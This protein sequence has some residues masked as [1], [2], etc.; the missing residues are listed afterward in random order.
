MLKIKSPDLKALEKTFSTAGKWHKVFV[1]KNMLTLGERIVF[2]MRQATSKHRYTGK[3]EESVKSTYKARVMRLEIGPRAKR[4]KWDA[5]LLLERGTGPIPNLPFGPIQRWAEFRG[6]PAG[7]VWMSIKRKGVKAHPYLDRTLARGD[8]QVAIKNTAFRIGQ[9]L[10]AFS[11]QSLKS[12]AIKS[13]VQVF[14]A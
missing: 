5:G 4:G 11:L 9:D 2:I 10:A 13:D 6:I 7:P 12:G 1:K 3:F 14:E 8:T